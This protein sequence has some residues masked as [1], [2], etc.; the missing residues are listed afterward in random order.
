MV[1]SSDIK[2]P[3]TNIDN[4]ADE[5]DNE[6]IEKLGSGYK[7]GNKQKIVD[8]IVNIQSNITTNINQSINAFQTVTLIGGGVI[9]G[10]SMSLTMNA[11][12]KAIATNNNSIDIINQ[13]TNEMVSKIR[14]SVDDELVNGFKLAFEQNKSYFIGSGIV[15]GVLILLIV[16]MLFIRAS[17]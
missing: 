10:V 17:K 6:L 9:T 2:I 13:I 8:V 15:I 4:L 1:S 3:D 7:I 14:Q 12:M 11:V 5:I 16:I